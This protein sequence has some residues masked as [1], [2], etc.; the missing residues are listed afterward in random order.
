VDPWSPTEE[1]LKELF[2][3]DGEPPAD[4]PESVRDDI[5]EAGPGSTAWHAWYGDAPADGAQ[6]GRLDGSG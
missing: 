1:R 3:P 5:L 4:M 2:P 6:A